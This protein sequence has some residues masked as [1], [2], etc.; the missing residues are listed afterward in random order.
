MSTSEE[1][2]G[3]SVITLAG[4]ASTRVAVPNDNSGI[5]D[6]R[7]LSATATSDS[8]TLTLENSY[9]QRNHSNRALESR[10]LLGGSGRAHKVP[11]PIMLDYS[12]DL[13]FDVTDTSGVA[14]SIRLNFSGIKHYHPDA[15]KAFY[16]ISYLNARGFFY[17]YTTDS[18]VTLP[19]T[20][21]ETTATITIANAED[22]VVFRILSQSEEAY[23]FKLENVQNAKSWSNGWIHSDTIGNAEYYWDFEPQFIPRKTQLK[24]R[25]INLD[26]VPMA[27]NNVYFALVGISYSDMPRVGS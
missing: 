10:L 2:A 3:D 7:E 27:T 22:F 9:H 18:S 19:A 13:Y 17:V 15:M 12:N 6:I 11:F 23:K 4:G 24:L 8:Y 5:I 20:T 26:P 14:N 21:A 16:D 25:M 1:T